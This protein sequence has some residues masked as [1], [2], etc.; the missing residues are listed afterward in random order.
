MCLCCARFCLY[1]DNHTVLLVSG[2]QQT[3]QQD[4]RLHR[5]GI[6]HVEMLRFRCVHRTSQ[7]A[8]AGCVQIICASAVLHRHGRL[9]VVAVCAVMCWNT[10]RAHVPVFKIYCWNNAQLTDVLCLYTEITASLV[11]TLGL[12]VILSVLH[13]TSY[14]AMFHISLYCT[15]HYINLLVTVNL[16]LY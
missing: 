12:S 4:T 16:V 3:S 1:Y 10:V 9:Q 5:A 11:I 8:R 2:I 14:L 6:C 13:S 15:L 7:S